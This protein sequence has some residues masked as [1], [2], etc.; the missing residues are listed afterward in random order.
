MIVDLFL[1]YQFLRRLATPFEEWDAFKTGVIDERG[2]ILKK[3]KDRLL[4]KER[5]SFGLF[6]LMILKI[7]RLIEK[8]P[9][10]KTR[11]AS[12][13][14]ALYLIKEDWESMSEEQLEASIEE[15]FSNL[16]SIEES[17]DFKFEL[18][19]SLMDEDAP[20]NA[21]SSG[22]IAGMGYGGKDDVKVPRPAAS[23]Y[24]KK[25]KREQEMFYRVR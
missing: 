11:I 21:A 20:A 9:G 7:K 12:Y 5:E 19:S 25:N 2:N 16:E 24:K 3:R 17:T 14:A 22:S 10:G 4:V 18:F 23:K 13:A 1:V 8:V 15:Y 6:D